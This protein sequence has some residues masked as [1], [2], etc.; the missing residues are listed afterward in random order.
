MSSTTSNYISQIQQNYPIAGEG[1]SSQGFRDNFKNIALAL[2]TTNTD[3]EHLRAEYL[4]TLPVTY[5][6][7]NQLLTP[8]SPQ[9]EVGGDAM[10]TLVSKSVTTA[11]RGPLLVWVSCMAVAAHLGIAPT[12]NSAGAQLTPGDYNVKL[13][14]NNYWKYNTADTGINFYLTFT[15]PTGVVYRSDRLAYGVTVIKGAGAQYA[16][17]RSVSVTDVPAGTYNVSLQAI[18]YP[19]LEKASVRFSNLVIMET[20]Q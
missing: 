9:I 19:T 6:A 16:G 18:G 10:V 3:V 4:S 12:F 8:T 13:A 7:T 17:Q 5:S 11:G 14:D 15:T 1:N 20:K 2:G